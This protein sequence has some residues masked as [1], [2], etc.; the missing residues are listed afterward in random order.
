MCI[1]RRVQYTPGKEV[2]E[3]VMKICHA[4]P[5]LKQGHLE[6]CECQPEPFVGVNDGTNVLDL[7][8]HTPVIHHPPVQPIFAHTHS[9][10][11]RSQATRSGMWHRFSK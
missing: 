1:M 8:Q 4:A 2:P 3:F 6:L 10:R 5:A 11:T 7:T 9:P